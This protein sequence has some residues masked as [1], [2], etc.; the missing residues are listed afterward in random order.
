MRGGTTPNQVVCRLW[1]PHKSAAE[2]NS[3]S[4]SN[5][6]SQLLLH[7]SNKLHSCSDQN[8]NISSPFVSHHYFILFICLI[9]FIYF[10]V[11]NYFFSFSQ[12]SQCALRE[13]LFIPRSSQRT[14]LGFDNVVACGYWIFSSTR[15][16]IE[17]NLSQASF[18]A[19]FLVISSQTL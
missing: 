8:D 9:A 15:V 11:I 4:R 12:R 5:T 17:T 14:I 6:P 2:L 16:I 10:M 3:L 18:H 1:Q 13:R 19:G 7:C